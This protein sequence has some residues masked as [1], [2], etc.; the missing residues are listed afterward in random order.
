MHATHGL[1]FHK[2]A[3]PPLKVSR[4]TS[5]SKPERDSSSPRKPEWGNQNESIGH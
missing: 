2:I 5:C 4:T 3:V 1:V